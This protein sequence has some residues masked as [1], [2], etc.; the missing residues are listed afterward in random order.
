MTI[1]C[2]FFNSVT[3][4]R[5]Y[6]STDFS[7]IFD[8]VI[9]DGIF[10][11][12]GDSFLVTPQTGMNVNVGT[13]RAWFNG[14]WTYN[15]API[16]KAIA[17]SDP[18]LSRIDVVY[19]EVNT[20]NAT[21][22]N[23]VDVLTGTPAS[24]PTVPT[25]TMTSTV[26]QYALAHISVLPTITT[27]TA[28]HI[29]NQ[30]GS[31]ETP[32]VSGPLGGVSV[33]SLLTQWEAEWDAWFA[34]IQGQ[35]STAAETNL[36]NQIWAIVGDI[37]PPVTDLIELFQYAHELVYFKVFYWDED[38]EVGDG[39]LF[40]CVPPALDGGSITDLD[41]SVY[42]PSSTGLVTVTLHNCG[43]NPSTNGLDIGTASIDATEN[44]SMTAATPP[45]ITNPVLTAGHFVRV[46][47]D[48]IGTATQG[49]DVFFKVVL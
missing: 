44:T 13:G 3:G 45:T 41:I 23:K 31:L 4:D 48:A 49:L 9:E 40:W 35:L 24:N 15:D 14:T 25:L 2:G 47:I 1:T 5:V 12:I 22:F 32:F 7:R 37:N 43:T 27:I 30:V 39:K 10:A 21:R 38:L 28:L 20:D 26:K 18:V 19:L 33:D 46:D 17:A 34:A 8:G 16:V 6:D 29:D 36:Q 42:K 11:S